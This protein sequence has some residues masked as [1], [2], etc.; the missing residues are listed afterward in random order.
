VCSSDLAGS[1]IHLGNSASAYRS[2]I[3]QYS[4]GFTSAGAAK[5]DGLLVYTAGTGGMTLKT[6]GAGAPIAFHTPDADPAVSIASTGHM[7]LAEL[8]ANPGTSVLAADAALAFYTK[9]DKL[10]FAYNNGGTMTYLTLALDGTST[11]W[12]HTT[13]AP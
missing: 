9:A 4:T 10:A 8:S 2:Q 5:Q 11:T 3:I 7:V 13:T 1:G 6:A 12:S